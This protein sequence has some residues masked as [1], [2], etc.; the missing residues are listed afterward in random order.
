[1]CA[2]ASRPRARLGFGLSRTRLSQGRSPRFLDAHTAELSEAGAFLLV[3]PEWVYGP[4]QM[5]RLEAGHNAGKYFLSPRINFAPITLYFDGEGSLNGRRRLGSA[6][7]SWHR[8]WLE[9]PA[10][11][12]MPSPPG[13]EEAYLALGRLLSSK[14]VTAGRRRYYLSRSTKDLL[15]TIEDTSPPFDFIPWPPKR[16]QA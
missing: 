13:V 16:V 8:D 10:H 4:L 7:L 12:L 5:H 2:T 15:A 3:H 1:M 11:R 9:E 14:F 6:F